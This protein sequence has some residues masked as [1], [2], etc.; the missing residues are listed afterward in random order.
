MWTTQARINSC[1]A[2]KGET[3]TTHLELADEDGLVLGHDGLAHL[4]HLAAA[5][6]AVGLVVLRQR[7]R[8]DLELGQLRGDALRGV[9]QGGT[10]LLGGLQLLCDGFEFGGLGGLHLLQDND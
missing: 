7:A 2:Q 1:K 3:T 5:L 9:L 10:A 6:R 8:R 4:R